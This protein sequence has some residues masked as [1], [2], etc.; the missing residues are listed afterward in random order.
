[1]STFKLGMYIQEAAIRMTI[2]PAHIP[3]LLLIQRARV[4]RTRSMGRSL[5]ASLRTLGTGRII[6]KA[7]IKVR[8]SKKAIRIP[9]PDR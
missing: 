3:G 9:N 5:F 7:G 4:F 6:K 8:E 2:T 1:M